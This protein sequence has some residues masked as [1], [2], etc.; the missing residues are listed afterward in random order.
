MI[1]IEEYQ[2]EQYPNIWENLTEYKLQ[3]YLENLYDS[4]SKQLETQRYYKIKFSGIKL[5]SI[6]K[7]DVLN[8]M[9]KFLKES[10]KIFAYDMEFINDTYA[11]N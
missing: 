4:I 2:K 10:H 3:K 11:S 6:K 5:P 1:I 9:E 7:E 8:D